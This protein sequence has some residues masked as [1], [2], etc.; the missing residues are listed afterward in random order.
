MRLSGLIILLA[1]AMLAGCS[2]NSR[3][4]NIAVTGNSNP[5]S[6]PNTPPDSIKRMT[7]SELR[8]ALEQ[9]KA[10]VV[11]VRSEAQ[12]KEEHIKGAVNI[13]ENQIASRAK[14]LPK[15]KLLVFYCS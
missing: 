4:A 6:S 13:P 7:V 11:D 8:D 5:A 9:G 10:L 14:E 12:Y 2:A 3:P 1:A 15:D